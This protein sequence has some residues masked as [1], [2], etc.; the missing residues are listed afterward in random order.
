MT[1]GN[2]ASNNRK[3]ING[4]GITS[5]IPIDW[6]FWDQTDLKVIHTDATGVDTVW[7]YGASPGSWAY[8]GGDGSTGTVTFT[9]A[10]CASGERLTVI[11]AEKLDQPVDLDSGNINQVAIETAVDKLAA[12]LQREAERVDRAP[13]MKESTTSSTPTFPEPSAGKVVSWNTAGDDLENGPSVGD[14]EDAA[15]NASAAAASASAAA[16]S[17]SAASTS[18]TNAANSASA[19]ATSASSAQDAL[20]D[21][22]NAIANSSVTDLSDVTSAGSGEIITTAERDKLTGIEPSADVTDTA[23]VTAAGALMDSEVNSLSGI[24][25][26]S[27][28][29]D[30]TITPA[31]ATV[32]DDASISDMR[33]TLGVYSE[34]VTDALLANRVYQFTSR[35]AFVSGYA[36]L[37]LED[38]D[39]VAAEGLMYEYENGATYISD[40]PGFKPE[41]RFTTKH[42]GAV[43]DGIT[44]DADALDEYFAYGGALAVEQM[45]YQTPKTDWPGRRV[46]NGLG[47]NAISRPINLDDTNK[48]AVLVGFF[49]VAIGSSWET[50]G[51]TGTSELEAY[52]PNASDY[53]VYS[54]G[55]NYLKV[56]NCIFEC[57]N[58]CGGVNLTYG[59]EVIGSSIRHCAGVGVRGQVGNTWV[60]ETHIGQWEQTDVEYYDKDA[61]TGLGVLCQSGASDMRV[62]NCHFSWMRELIRFEGTN[63]H[64]WGGHYFNGCISYLAAD[65]TD[66]DDF[67][68][69]LMNYYSLG[70]LTAVRAYNFPERTYNAGAVTAGSASNDCSFNDVYLDNC[71]CEHYN[72]R[73]VWTNPK[74]GHKAGST[75][76]SMKDY[77]W[78]FYAA[79]VDDDLD[80]IIKN[81]QIQVNTGTKAKNIVL[82]NYST[83]TWSLESYGLV[84]SDAV[85]A[86]TPTE[87]DGI[88]VEPPTTVMTLFGQNKD[89]LRKFYSFATGMF[90][91]YADASTTKDGNDFPIWLR[92]GAV[93]DN[94][95]ARAANLK[96][97]SVDGGTEYFSTGEDGTILG[98]GA[99]ATTFDPSTG[100]ASGAA[101]QSSVT[102]TSAGKAMI[103]G[104]GGLLN[105]AT[106]TNIG[107]WDDTTIASGLYNF[108]NATSNI[109]S[110]P[111]GY[112]TSDF[113][114]VLVERYNANLFRQT[115]YRIQGSTLTTD[116]LYMTRTYNN[117]T[118]STWER[119]YS[120]SSI[121]GTV[122]EDGS[123]N[124]TGA[125][126]ETG[127]AIATGAY[128][129]LADGTMIVE[130]RAISSTANA[131]TT[132][133]YPA[134]F[135][136]SPAPFVNARYAS[137]MREANIVTVGTSSLTFRTADLSDDESVTPSVDIFLVGRWF[138]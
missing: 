81:V 26:M 61:Y 68:T 1:I 117:G 13:R 7:I 18:E 43:C 24:K 91:G 16:L 30:T 123:G 82:A 112:T 113:G 48:T 60:I 59:G 20:T 28:P 108:S 65:R 5:S 36:A 128:T 70:S 122:S 132:F 50:A 9:A 32:L 42:F 103:V 53:M 45:A 23:N 102:D 75:F 35:A 104:A 131:A 34:T 6:S 118:W 76:G 17:A 21:I 51:G 29:D 27:V 111:T 57:N 90:N 120:S 127:G 54:T 10:D 67:D 135:I 22:N 3:Q 14:I 95:Q 116:P 129:M 8:T 109:A 121:V 62:I 89:P 55:A 83:F 105:T 99:A 133:T 110:R 106:G 12:R 72:N 94:L 85:N 15:S 126:Y 73:V 115:A 77:W 52:R 46:Y 92:F 66:N 74:L 130:A 96:L 33:A 137:G 4:N 69:A 138:A 97:K 31:A 88:S 93:G 98:A 119:I 58:L 79:E 136:E 80:A 47:I 71:H 40:L 87:G 11:P 44:D 101:I 114:V 86:T 39:H 37:S 41:P 125:L 107:D 100:L 25:S 134:A 64:V 49:F 78:K 2:P 56:E 38:G 63:C 84:G 19:A 124:P